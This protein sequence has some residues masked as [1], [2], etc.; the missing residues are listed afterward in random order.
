VTQELYRLLPATIDT[1]QNND[2]AFYN[3]TSTSSSSSLAQQTHELDQVS[4]LKEI[5]S[6]GE[7]NTKAN[8]ILLRTTR[9]QNQKPEETTKTAAH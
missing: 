5:L 4:S 9:K 7:D 1:Q 3:L 8:G 2:Q 6:T